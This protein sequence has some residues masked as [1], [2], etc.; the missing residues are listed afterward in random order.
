LP[1]RRSQSGVSCD[2]AP[3]GKISEQTFRPKDCRKLC[4]DAFQ[5]RQH[6][7]WCRSPCFFRRSEHGISL[8]LYGLDL[9]EKQLKPVEL[10]ADLPL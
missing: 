5:V 7:R 1:R 2:L 10:A 3:V 9:F 4:S 6:R 8:S